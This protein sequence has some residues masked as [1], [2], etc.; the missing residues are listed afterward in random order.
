MRYF[1]VL[2]ICFPVPDGRVFLLFDVCIT[3]KLST[4]QAN[5]YRIIMYFRS[6]SQRFLRLLQC[7]LWLPRYERLSFLHLFFLT[8]FKFFFHVSY[9]YLIENQNS[10]ERTFGTRVVKTG[11]SS[12]LGPWMS[13]VQIL[14]TYH[15][16]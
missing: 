10:K 14:P 1:G 11:W 15:Y 5:T 16:L 2:T 7:M 13:L 4:L 9:C 6:Q 3:A 8:P 12:G